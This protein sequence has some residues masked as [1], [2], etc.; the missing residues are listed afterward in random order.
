MDTPTTTP[1]EPES[2]VP[3]DHPPAGRA[4]ANPDTTGI[5][6]LI[7]PRADGPTT[8]DEAARWREAALLRCQHPGW[9][10]IWLARVA[11][12]RAYRRFLGARRDTVLTAATSGELAVR[13]VRAERAAKAAPPK[14][15][16]R[17]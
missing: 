6:A 16:R 1:P 2:A 4:A 10:I 8:K 9:V 12:Y 5:D 17:R 11:Q 13:I 7:G 14:R 15:P 3:S